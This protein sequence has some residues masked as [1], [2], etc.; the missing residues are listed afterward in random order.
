VC[1][2]NGAEVSQ[3]VALIESDRRG[4]HPAAGGPRAGTPSA[5]I[6]FARLGPRTGVRVHNEDAL[7]RTSKHAPSG[8]SNGEEA[9][10]TLKKWWDGGGRDIQEKVGAKYATFRVLAI[11]GVEMK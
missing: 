2:P 8:D 4:I 7:P 1:C 3:N 11:E 5:G 6:G 9:I 10:G